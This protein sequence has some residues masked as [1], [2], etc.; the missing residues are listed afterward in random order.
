MQFSTGKVL[1]KIGCMGSEVYF[2][3]LI[4]KQVLFRIIIIHLIIQDFNS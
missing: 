2:P 3:S 4:K 1:K